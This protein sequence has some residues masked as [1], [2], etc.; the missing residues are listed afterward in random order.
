MSH[1]FIFAFISIALGNWAKKILL[2]FILENVLPMFSS[3]SFM[4][5]C[6]IFRSS[7]HFVFII[8]AFLMWGIPSK[9]KTVSHFCLV[10]LSH[11][12]SGSGEASLWEILT[13]V[14]KSPCHSQSADTKNMPGTLK[15]IFR[16]K[17]SF[18]FWSYVRSVG[19]YSALHTSCANFALLRQNL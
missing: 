16:F 15:L 9:G 18:F 11:F 4:V 12:P 14:R 19:T 10:F 8:D 1:L 7:T 13:P 5:S 17:S 2:R 6:L 3:R